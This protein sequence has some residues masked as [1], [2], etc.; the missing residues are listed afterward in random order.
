MK[1]RIVWIDDSGS[2]I[3]SVS[4]DVEDIFK[5]LTFIPD[6]EP[7]EET[8]PAKKFI[9]ST[10]ADLILV[11]CNLPGGV[12][13]D[14]F[15]K[16]LR[17]ERCFAHVI[18]YSQDADNLQTMNEDEHF[19]HVTRRDDILATLKIVADQAHSK[20][21]HPA[22]MRGL[23]LSEFIDLENLMEDLISQCFKGEEDYIK[24]TVIQKGG[25]SF[26]L[27]AKKKFITRLIKES[28][29]ENE[30]LKEKLDKVSFTST[31][32]ERN[33]IAKRN[34][35]AH[36]HPKYDPESG[37]ITLV[38]AIENVD[39]NADWFHKTREQIHV[40]KQKI[41]SLINLKLYLVVNP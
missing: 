35:L 41:R 3:K 11:D 31:Q 34:V 15:I 20:Y 7:F 24:R 13:G 29:A 1:F 17:S 37:K 36:A 2:W 8:E 32:F 25:E 38:S 9:L 6:I 10:Y 23:L 40:Q 39:F 28:G 14:K 30:E 22:F 33:V 4:S 18:F 26:S 5:N 21:K 19:I 16:E 27:G 12:R